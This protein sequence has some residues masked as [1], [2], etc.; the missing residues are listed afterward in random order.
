[1]KLLTH[2]ADITGLRGL[3]FGIK[4]DYR[5]MGLP[6][7]AF[8]YLFNVLQ[9]QRKYYYI[10]LGWNL[11]D[12]ALINQWYKEGGLTIHNTYHIYRKRISNV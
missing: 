8:D 12:N 6:L 10:E 11:A 2:R 5:E 1:L 9:K 3:M 4:K 7:V